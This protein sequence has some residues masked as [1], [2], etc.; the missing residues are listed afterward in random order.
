MSGRELAVGRF[1]LVY[2]PSV[3]EAKPWY[4]NDH[5]IIRGD[6][7]QWHLFGITHEE[8]ADATDEKSF[9]HATANDLQ[10][11]WRKQS[12]VLTAD[13]DYGE[14]HL[15][16]PHVLAHQHLYYMFYAGGGQDAQRAGINL[17]V[18][19]DL[20]HWTRHPGGTLFRDGFEARDPMVLRAGDRWVM[21]YC[22]TD[23]PAGGHHVVC[24]RTSNDLVNWSDREIA[25]TSR[26]TGTGAGDTE[27]PFVVHHAGRYYLFIGPCGAYGPGDD[28]YVCTAV[29]RSETPWHFPESALVAKFPSH[30]AEVVEDGEDWWVT[31]A[32]WG[33]GG[34]HLAPLHW[35]PA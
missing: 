18:S 4:I 7:G 29:Y 20:W 33:Q 26:R 32:G 19:P 8:P 11:P 1:E 10:G 17:A 23:E 5:T 35:L 9:A 12:P 21:Y 13:P 25:F 15:W 30:A 16:A 27:S 31:H 6:D 3:G 24:W 34:V 14:T 22:A 2:D 28:G